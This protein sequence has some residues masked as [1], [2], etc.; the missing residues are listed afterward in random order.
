MIETP[1]QR[2]VGFLNLDL[3]D[4][5]IAVL[6]VFGVDDGGSGGCRRVVG[7]TVGCHGRWCMVTLLTSYQVVRVEQALQLVPAQQVTQFH[8]LGKRTRLN[9][10]QALHKTHQQTLIHYFLEVTLKKT[11][12]DTPLVLQHIVTNGRNTSLM[13]IKTNQNF[14]TLDVFLETVKFVL[15]S[16]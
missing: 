13:H 6:V 16:L 15:I 7:Y 8:R 5:D 3:Y 9:H 4:F 14:S 12:W 10:F 2:L 1:Y 11:L